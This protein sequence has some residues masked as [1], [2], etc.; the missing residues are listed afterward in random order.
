MNGKKIPGK[1]P[2]SNLKVSTKD[3]SVIDIKKA[4]YANASKKVELE[5]QETRT[6][7]FQLSATAAAKPASKVDAK[8]AALKK[9]RDLSNKKKR[10]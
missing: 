10:R 3:I 5:P 8:A 6:V 1:T 7:M 4:G 9:A 2:I